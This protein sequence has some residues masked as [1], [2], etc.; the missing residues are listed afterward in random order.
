MTKYFK[1]MFSL[2]TQHAL[3][4]WKSKTE[5]HSVSSAEQFEIKDSTEE[6]NSLRDANEN[7]RFKV[8]RV[9]NQL[10]QQN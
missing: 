10:T 6:L 2:S 8:E 7:L 5:F 9:Q 1:K 4:I 3:S